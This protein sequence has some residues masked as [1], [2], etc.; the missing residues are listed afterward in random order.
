MR[1]KQHHN[2]SRL[3]THVRYARR[4]RWYTVGLCFAVVLALVET[5][6]IWRKNS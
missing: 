5:V 2:A 1:P 4:P 6:N 3:L